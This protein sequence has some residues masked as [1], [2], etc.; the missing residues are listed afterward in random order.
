MGFGN[1]YGDDWNEEIVAGYTGKLTSLGISEII[2]ADT[3]GIST[4]DK[5]SSLFSLLTEN[6]PR[7]SF[8]LHLHSRPEEAHEKLEAAIES[9]C[10]RFDTALR[11]FGGCPMANDELVGNIATER[12]INLLERKSIEHHLNMQA[13]QEAMQYSAE[14]FR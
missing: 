7:T 8:G 1:P 11:G 3:I 12:L 2:L 4:P 6:F 5:I 10:K 14:L 13:W 9:G